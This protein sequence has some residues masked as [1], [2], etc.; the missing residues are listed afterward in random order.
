MGVS[1]ADLTNEDKKQCQPHQEHQGL[2]IAPSRWTKVNGRE[3][4]FFVH[5]LLDALARLAETEYMY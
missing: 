3:T 2:A 1:T 4:A 5:A